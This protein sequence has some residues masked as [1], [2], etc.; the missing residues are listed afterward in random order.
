MRKTDFASGK[1]KNSSGEKR[2]PCQLRSNMKTAS[3]F[4][5]EHSNEFYQIKTNFNCNSKMVVYLIECGNPYNGST[6]AKF[7][8]RANN[9]NSTHRNF[10]L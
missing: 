8:V 7:R 4:K 10:F 6:V 1:R 9:Y 5:S 2:P 3:T